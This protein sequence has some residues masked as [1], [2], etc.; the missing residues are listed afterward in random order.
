MKRVEYEKLDFLPSVYAHVVHVPCSP[1]SPVMVALKAL[2][3]MHPDQNFYMV[4]CLP[5]TYRQSGEPLLQC[6]IN[7]LH[8]GP[9][10]IHVQRGYCQAQPTD[11]S[12]ESTH[13]YIRIAKLPGIPQLGEVQV[14]N[15]SCSCVGRQISSRCTRAGWRRSSRKR[16]SKWLP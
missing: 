5:E 15:S 6:Q 16:R 7:F 10:N 11:P 12:A 4:Q 13:C 1:I 3:P 14:T 8:L 2:P 9:A